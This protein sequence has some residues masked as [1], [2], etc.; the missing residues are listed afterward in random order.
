MRFSNSLTYDD[1]S[2]DDDGAVQQGEVYRCTV[3]CGS[4]EPVQVILGVGRTIYQ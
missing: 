4:G 3:Q 2:R 1:P